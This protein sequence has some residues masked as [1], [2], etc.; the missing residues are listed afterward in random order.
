MSTSPRSPT[1][2]LRLDIQIIEA[3][4]A[5]P[6]WWRPW[7]EAGRVLADLGLG[8]EAAGGLR[9]A[10]LVDGMLAGCGASLSV[11]AALGAAHGALRRHLARTL[12]G[13]PLAWE[14]RWASGDGTVCAGFAPSPGAAVDAA[15]QA[16]GWGVA[17]EL[18]T[19]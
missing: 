17:Q 19:R 16:A 3:H 18:P 1:Q 7:S 15:L 10:V 4:G 6:G 9:W 2:P 14:L 5:D 12:R 8:R 13:A 11:E